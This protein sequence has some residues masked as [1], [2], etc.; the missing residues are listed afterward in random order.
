[1]PDLSISCCGPVRSVLLLSRLPWNELEG[2]SILVSRQSHTSIALLRILFAFHHGMSVR[3]VPGDCT[4]TLAR[5]QS[6][7]AFL[8]I[9]DEALRLTELPKELVI[10]GG[11]YIACELAHFFGSMGS[12]VTILQ[13]NVRL[14]PDED[15]EVGQKFGLNPRIFRF[16]HKDE[17]FWRSGQGG[18]LLK[19][20]SD[21]GPIEEQQL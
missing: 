7:A 13:R 14:L 15:E 9:G 6:P 16:V 5:K 2:E 17:V 1:M 12:K 11:G 8:A 4:E 3:L 10:I 21:A 18:A 20:D 19:G